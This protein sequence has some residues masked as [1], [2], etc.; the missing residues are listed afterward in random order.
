MF[1]AVLVIYLTVGTDLEP[2]L[3]RGMTKKA[4]DA[5]VAPA[6]RETKGWEIACLTPA[7]ARARATPSAD[8]KFHGDGPASEYWD[9][10]TVGGRT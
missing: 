6:P 9:G 8:E 3:Y 1:E 4:C 2:L 10:A 5:V 7:E